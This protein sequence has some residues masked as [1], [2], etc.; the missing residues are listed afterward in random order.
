M[1][2]FFGTDGIRGFANQPPMTPDFFVKL[3]Q[4]LGIYFR[5]Q[6]PRTKIIVGKDTRRSGYMFEHSL[7]AGICSVGVD[8]YLTGPIPTPGVAYLTRG[9]RASAGIMLSASHNPYYDN[10]IKI[11]APDGFKL[12]DLTELKIEEMLSEDLSKYF[13]SRGDIGRTR[14]VD[15]AKGQYAV[16]LKEQFPKHLTL[17]GLRIVLD[18]AN[19]AAYKVAPKVLEELGAELFII[20]NK[21]DGVNINEQCGALH[22]QNLQAEVLK[23]RA[24]LG[25]ALDG[26]ADRL[27]I[28]DNKGNVLDGDVVLAI[29]A[30]DLLEK[31]KLNNNAL[32]ATTM[33]GFG[34]EV[35]M[36]KAGGKLIRTDVG[37]KYVIDEMTTNGHNFGGE[38]SGH[39]IFGDYCTTGDGLLAALKFLEV[40]IE[41]KKSAFELSQVL[42]N[43]PQVLKNIPITKKVPLEDLPKTSKLVSEFEERLGTE[44]RVV[45]RYSGTE[46]VARLMIEGK[47]DLEIQAMCDQ[48]VQVFEKELGEYK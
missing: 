39:I 42:I 37:D 35:T 34:L 19:G 12:P 18:P 41:K 36:N 47:S 33:S 20:N 5:Q 29:L 45:F 10:G 13:A 27:V 25:I 1:K 22:P 17:D 38:R 6:D 40:I 21:P 9:L 3:G 43:I 14:V 7:C 32:V 11:F 46:K 48:F 31:G 4:V 28:V 15:D 8:V 26:D 30:L 23:Y 2:K 16:F 44:G 24:D